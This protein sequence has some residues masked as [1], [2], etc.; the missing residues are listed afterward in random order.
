MMEL[1]LRCKNEYI[2]LDTEI[3]VCINTITLFSLKF[4]IEDM[5]TF[6]NLLKGVQEVFDLKYLSTT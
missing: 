3:F 2:S 1:K 5:S 6:G 4:L